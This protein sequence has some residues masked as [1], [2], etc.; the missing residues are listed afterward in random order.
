MLEKLRLAW[1]YRADIKI[2]LAVIQDRQSQHSR[3]DAIFKAMDGLGAGE[4]F[5]T[6]NHMLE[7]SKWVMSKRDGL[8]QEY[9]KTS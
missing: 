3:P 5:R 4:L 1:R 9:Q 6:N 8:I 2:L 7:A